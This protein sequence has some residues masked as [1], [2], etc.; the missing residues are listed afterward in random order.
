MVSNEGVLGEGGLDLADA[1]ALLRG[2]IAEAQSRLAAESGSGGTEVLFGLGEITLELGMELTRTRGANGGL[3][4]SVVSL[5]GRQEKAERA[6]HRVTVRLD[7]HDAQGR[8]VDVRD[9]G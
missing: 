2:Q 3:R 6:T 5:G 1:V 7:P 4:F 9:R 8:P